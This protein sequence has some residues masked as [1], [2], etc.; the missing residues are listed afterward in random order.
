MSLKHSQEKRE[1]AIDLYKAG[2]STHQIA[3]EIGISQASVYKIVRRAGILRSKS[4]AHLLKQA[5][6]REGVLRLIRKHPE[7]SVH[8]IA[9]EIGVLPRTAQA[10]VQDVDGVYSS[11]PEDAEHDC[12]ATI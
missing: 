7:R 5:E 3:D 10:W 11:H 9:R 4:A 6:Q 1:A 12:V 2:L 8:S